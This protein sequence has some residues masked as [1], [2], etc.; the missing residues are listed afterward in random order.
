MANIRRIIE[1]AREYQNNIY[2][3]FIDYSSL[4]LCRS[5]QT[6]E[7]SLRQ[8]YQTTLPASWEMCMPLKKQQLELDLEEQTGYK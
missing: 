3:C 1:K 6:V 4:W 5:Q 2:F 7:N 8:E